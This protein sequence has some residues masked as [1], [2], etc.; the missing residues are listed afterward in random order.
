M[1][2]MTKQTIE[3]CVVEAAIWGMSIVSVHAM[4]QAFFENT[5]FQLSLG[6]AGSPTSASMGQRSPLRR[7]RGNCLPSS[8]AI[9]SQD[10]VNSQ[11][12]SRRAS[13]G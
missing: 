5:G 7:R 1:N 3:R 10:G 2:D 8:A 9:K 11:S 6:A 4:R 13:S 12:R